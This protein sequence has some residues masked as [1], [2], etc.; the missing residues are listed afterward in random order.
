[1][2]QNLQALGGLMLKAIPTICLFLLVYFYLRSMLFTP[3]E[4]VLQRRGVL[5][6]GA[7][8]AAEQSLSAAERKQQEYEKKFNEA[9]AE[10]YRAQEEIRR[11]WLD[12]QAAQVADARKKAEEAVRLARAQ[13]V[14][15]MAGTRE[16]LTVPSA[17]LAEEITQAVLA[18]RVRSAE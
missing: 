16:N 5:T 3:I 4:K 10:V 18:R 15:E 12:Q 11:G 13:I 1:M 17:E 9:R 2:E 6:E 8:K 7:R 14:V